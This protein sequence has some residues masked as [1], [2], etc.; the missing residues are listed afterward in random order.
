M[1]SGVWLAKYSFAHLDLVIS[2]VFQLCCLFVA[3]LSLR[4]GVSRDTAN[5]TLKALKFILLTA[6]QLLSAAL[7]VTI[8]GLQVAK[9]NADMIEI[10]LDIRTVYSH[11]GFNPELMRNVC[12]PKCFMQYDSTSP[13]PRRCTYKRSQARNSKPCNTDLFSQQHTRHGLKLVPRSLFT[14]QSFQS[15]ILFFLS[16]AQIVDSLHQ[17]FAASCNPSIHHRM[18]DIHHSPAWSGLRHGGYLRSSYHLVFALYI[19]WFNPFTNKIAGEFKL[20]TS[21][22][23]RIPS[24][25]Y[26]NKI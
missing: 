1:V 23:S 10:P 11:Q 12:C 26:N 25:T 9:L 2:P 22:N 19:D 24:L 20:L 17:T 13:I 14:T 6:L 7:S 16:R 21:L 15:W 8:P 3:W 18:H 4:G 5:K